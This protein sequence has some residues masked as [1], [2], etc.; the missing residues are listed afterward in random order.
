MAA[1]KGGRG[2]SDEQERE[3]AGRVG[4]A[5]GR[6]RPQKEKTRG[7]YVGAVIGNLIVLV[8]ANIYPLWRP[9]THGVVTE[10]WVRILWAVDL[11]LLIQIGG[12][13]ILL[14][15]SPRALRRFMDLSF[16]AT[17][18]LSVAVFYAVFPLDF[19]RVVGDW[20]NLLV[21][22]FLVL[23]MVGASIGVVVGIFRFFSAAWRSAD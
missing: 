4:R 18:L 9:L 11:S 1:L 23:A 15:A 8:L 16:A 3:G 12:N 22:I 21:R 14:F 6:A 13:L 10:A 17:G 7:D 19:S 20:L 5:R 2:M